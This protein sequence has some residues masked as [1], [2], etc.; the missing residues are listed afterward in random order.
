[1]ALF[2][3]LLRSTL[4]ATC[5]FCLALQLS[6]SEVGDTDSYKE[7]LET[8]INAHSNHLYLLRLLKSV[9]D[10][11]D[12]LPEIEASANST[13]E[14]RVLPT[15]LIV[16][17]NKSTAQ[18]LMDEANSVFVSNISFSDLVNDNETYQMLLRNRERKRQT[19]ILTIQQEILQKLGLKSGPNVTARFSAEE[20]EELLKTIV[21]SDDNETTCISGPDDDTC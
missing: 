1:M 19:R 9:V 13:Q 3:S 12:D 21:R 16:H 15:P 10:D 6:R 18:L 2:D 8:D 17:L 20:R 14:E 5:F 4:C 11:S 7:D